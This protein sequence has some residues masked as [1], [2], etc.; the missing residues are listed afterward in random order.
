MN[1][2]EDIGNF[3]RFEASRLEQPIKLFRSMV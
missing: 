1:G 3:I 2:K